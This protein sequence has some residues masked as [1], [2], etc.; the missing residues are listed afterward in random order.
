MDSYSPW[1]HDPAACRAILWSTPTFCSMIPWSR[2]TMTAT[3]PRFACPPGSPSCQFLLHQLLS[4]SYALDS[5]S[6]KFQIMPSRTHDLHKS[7]RAV[8]FA[9]AC[10]LLMST[11]LNSSTAPVLVS[12]SPWR[13]FLP[14]LDIPVSSPCSST[15]YAA[16]F[17]LTN[18][19]PHKSALPIYPTVGMAAS[20]L[21]HCFEQPAEVC[22]LCTFDTVNKKYTICFLN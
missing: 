7:L 21:R 12:L 2:K 17:S 16:D 11:L 10:G 3:N 4:H 5:P 9:S 19:Q 8:E 1:S 18:R 13:V 6:S 15:I 14:G 20:T 22:T